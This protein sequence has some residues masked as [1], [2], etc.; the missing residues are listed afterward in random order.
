LPLHCINDIQ[1]VTL[2]YGLHER[3]TEKAFR[4]L[5]LQ[6]T[7]QHQET[8]QRELD[9]QWSRIIRINLIFSASLFEAECAGINFRRLKIQLKLFYQEAKSTTSSLRIWMVFSND[10]R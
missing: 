1:F 5:T 10:A 2:G 9:G 6:S 7:M 8:E 4:V 3:Q